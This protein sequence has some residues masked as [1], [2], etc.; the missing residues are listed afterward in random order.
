VA[1]QFHLVS[2]RRR[3]KDVPGTGRALANPFSPSRNHSQFGVR[4][5]FSFLPPLPAPIPAFLM[6]TSSYDTAYKLIAGEA[7]RSNINVAP[8]SHVC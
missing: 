8:C 6:H 2:D 3:P 5:K 4:G 1:E 7:H